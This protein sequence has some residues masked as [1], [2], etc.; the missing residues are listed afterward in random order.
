MKIIEKFKKDF[1][2]SFEIFPPKTEAGT[3][4]LMNELKT[5]SA[6]SPAYI[7]V[8]YG[9]GG[10][11]REKTLDLALDLKDKFNVEPLV[12]F[13]C[14]GA[15][16]DGITDYINIVKT[17][18][19]ENILALRGDPPEGQ[20]KF[21]PPENGFAYANELVEHIS[22][23]E[24]FCIAVAGYPE[25][26][27]EAPD[28]D[29]DIDNLKRKIDAGG[30]YVITQLF[31]DNEDFYRFY[32]KTQQKGIN[33]PILPGIMPVTNLTQLEKIIG[34]FDPKIP[35]GLRDRL[36]SASSN[37]DM[38]KA[39]VEYSVNQCREL[40]SFGIPGFHFYPLNKAGAVSVIIDSL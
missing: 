16:R 18:K 38:Y 3:E 19:L 39:G 23:M 5:L 8:T 29:T 27:V 13:T 20:D 12:H 10:S 32:D 22:G 35:A 2:I 17:N 4:R 21:I 40:K 11:T 31:F 26:H 33:V 28:L 30:E 25:G 7:S 34:M 1:L 9:A 6:Y 14:V 24:G 37:D 15:D 36:E